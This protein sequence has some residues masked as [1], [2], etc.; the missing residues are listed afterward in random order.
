MRTGIFGIAL[1]AC[2]VLVVVRL[3][4]LPFWPQGKNYQAYFT[5]AGGISPGNDV[6]VSGI[7][8]GKVTGVEL[9]GDTAKVTFTV[10][11]K[12]RV[13]D[14]SLV[15]IKTDTVL[16]EKSLAVTPQ[17]AGRRRRSR[18]AAPRL[19]TRSTPRCRISART[20]VNSTSRSSSRRCRR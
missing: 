15:S 7:T 3:H 6:N 9:A 13:G 20:P 4:Q 11:R 18:W 19:R 17:G 10:D 2:V 8:V 12:I 1:V 16:G 5:D 14:Q